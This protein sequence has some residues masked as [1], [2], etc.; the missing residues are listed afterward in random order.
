MQRQAAQ[1]HAGGWDVGNISCLKLKV[2][3]FRRQIPT[4]SLH[5]SLHSHTY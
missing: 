2:G 1:D 5:D 4:T 3:H